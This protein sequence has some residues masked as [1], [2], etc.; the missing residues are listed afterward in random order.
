MGSGKSTI[1]KMLAEKLNF[2]VLDTDQLIE[3][4]EGLSVKAIF[5]KH[6]EGYFRDCETAVLKSFSAQNYVLAT[7][8]GIVT[9]RNAPI[10]KELGLIIQLTADFD[11]LYSRIKGSDRP[12]L[13]ENYKTLFIERQVMYDSISQFTV[14]ST[15]LAK[16]EV[17]ELIFVSLL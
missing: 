2:Q 13:Q 12:L 4:H 6:G 15:R 14:N 8:G 17:V 9:Q 7:G 10:L 5:A 3:E 1:G 11:E 16:N